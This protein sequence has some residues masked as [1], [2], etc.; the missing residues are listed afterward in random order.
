MACASMDTTITSGSVS[1]Q[2]LR[3]ST[4]RY[5]VVKL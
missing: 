5:R 1:N 3:T 2:M 4:D